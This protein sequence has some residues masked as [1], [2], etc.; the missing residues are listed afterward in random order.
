MHS[1]IGK[2]LTNRNRPDPPRFSL[3]AG[4]EAA[5]S[6]L[7]IDGDGHLIRWKCGNEI[8]DA[9]LEPGVTPVGRNFEKRLQYEG[10]TVHARVRHD[11]GG[12]HAADVAVKGKE[13]KI[14][15]PR[16]V[17]DPPDATKI[18]FDAVQHGEYLGRI[19]GGLDRGD[20]VDVPGN[21]GRRYGGARV[22][23]RP[24]H[25]AN[26]VVRHGGERPFAVAARGAEP[27]TWK[28][29]T[30]SDQ[31]QTVEPAWAE[32][33]HLRKEI[34]VITYTAIAPATGGFGAGFRKFAPVE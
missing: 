32:T 31:D 28:V 11:H 21:V 19:G 25:E 18:V 22:P 7:V 4:I 15:G 34:A 24:A 3:I 14:Q 29:G 23:R 20:A 1:N 10:A 17:R 2:T 12:A 26:S 16:R 13:I 6:H 8:A 9:S 5:T 27:G 30:N 33:S